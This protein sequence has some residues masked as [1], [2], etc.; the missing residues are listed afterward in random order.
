[1]PRMDSSRILVLKGGT[2]Q[3]DPVLAILVELFKSVRTAYFL[4][5]IPLYYEEHT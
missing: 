1:M 3:S 5:V 4:R 2:V